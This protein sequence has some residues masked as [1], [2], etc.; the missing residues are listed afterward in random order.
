MANVPPSCCPGGD[1]D[2]ANG[3]D[4]PS[5]LP[6]QHFGEAGDAAAPDG[7]GE[8]PTE[9]VD[10]DG[11]RHVRLID[12]AADGAKDAPPDPPADEPRSFWNLMVCSFDATDSSGDHV[13]IR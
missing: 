6:R 7:G 10:D 12:I 13:V 5:T 1:A 9:S 11:V 8:S 3:P 2:G 4:T